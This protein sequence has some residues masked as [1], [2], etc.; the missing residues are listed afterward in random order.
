MPVIIYI[1]YFIIRNEMHYEYQRFN[2]KK[3]LK[4]TCAYFDPNYFFGEQILKNLQC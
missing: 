1:R 3:Y 2:F 4:N